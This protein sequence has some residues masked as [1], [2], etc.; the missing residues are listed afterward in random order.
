MKEPL[1]NTSNLSTG[2]GKSVV[3]KCKTGDQASEELSGIFGALTDML[4]L[5]KGR[6]SLPL[7]RQKRK[8]LPIY[9]KEHVKESRLRNWG[10]QIGL[11]AEQS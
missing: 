6:F 7:N 2:N 3:R 9:T 5:A 10:K 11:P 1:S 8:K 4:N